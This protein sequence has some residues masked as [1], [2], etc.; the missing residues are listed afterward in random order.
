MSAKGVR[1]GTGEVGEG[2]EKRRRKPVSRKKGWE[3]AEEDL[4][5]EEESGGEAVA[6]ITQEGVNGTVNGHSRP[7][8]GRIPR[9]ALDLFKKLFGLGD[10]R[11]DDRAA[12]GVICARLEEKAGNATE[13]DVLAEV[14]VCHLQ[15]KC[16][17]EAAAHFLDKSGVP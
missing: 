10:W 5:D 13:N 1:K 14:M 9:P 8:Y 4:G 7:Q 15:L 16:R 12:A 2:G 3:S 17:P 6:A 11:A